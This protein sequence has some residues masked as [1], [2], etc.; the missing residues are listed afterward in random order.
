MASLK[1]DARQDV[2]GNNNL[3]LK[4]KKTLKL[5]PCN[6]NFLASKKIRTKFGPAIITEKKKSL[7]DV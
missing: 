2:W 3:M 4:K 7:K 6:W 5:V 1:Q